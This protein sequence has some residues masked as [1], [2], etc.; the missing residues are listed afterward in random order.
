MATVLSGH[1]FGKALSRVE[2]K[3]KEKHANLRK[4]I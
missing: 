3:A 1:L 4:I 2:A